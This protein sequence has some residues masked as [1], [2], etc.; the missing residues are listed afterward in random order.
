MKVFICVGLAIFA[1]LPM[2][3]DEYKARSGDRTVREM[4]VEATTQLIKENDHHDPRN[5]G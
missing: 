1:I 4:L 5:P 2:L 3:Q